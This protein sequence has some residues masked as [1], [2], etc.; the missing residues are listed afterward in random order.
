MAPILGEEFLIMWRSGGLHITCKESTMRDEAQTVGERSLRH[1]KNNKEMFKVNTRK[2]SSHEVILQIVLKQIETKL[3]L[4]PMP[5]DG[6]PRVRRRSRS[7]AETIKEFLHEKREHRGT[8]EIDFD[9]ILKK[10]ARKIYKS[11]DID[12][13]G[14]KLGFEPEDIQRYIQANTGSADYMGTLNMLRD[15]RKRTP[16]A[17]ERELLRNALNDTGLN[18]L[19]DELFSENTEGHRGYR[20]GSYVPP[21]SSSVYVGFWGFVSLLFVFWFFFVFN[22]DERY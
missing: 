21:Y 11:S 1:L 6:I 7:A 9:D 4:V 20:R 10:I 5:L 12:D 17:E 18:R 3:L 16:E 2:I 8:S 19:A 14:S 22:F 13:L 15:W